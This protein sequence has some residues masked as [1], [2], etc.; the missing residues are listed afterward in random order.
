MRFGLQ[1]E[2]NRGKRKVEER[3]R[4]VGWEK[5]RERQRKGQRERER[6]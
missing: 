6:D 4:E 3:E 5:A 2:L 1:N